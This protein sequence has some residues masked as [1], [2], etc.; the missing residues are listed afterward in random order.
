MLRGL[1]YGFI[2]SALIAVVAMAVFPLPP[3][4]FPDAT[5]TA[6]AASDG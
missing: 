3:E 6:P 2:L 1:L 4:R 5:P